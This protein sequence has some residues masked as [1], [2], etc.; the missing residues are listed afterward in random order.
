MQ[1]KNFLGIFF[2]NLHKKY[3][4]KFKFFQKF[5]LNAIGGIFC[6][7][8]LSKNHIE[9]YYIGKNPGEMELRGNLGEKTRG[10]KN[11]PQKKTEAQPRSF[12]GDYFWVRVFFCKKLLELPFTRM[13]PKT[14]RHKIARVAIHEDKP[15]KHEAQP[16]AFL[17]YPSE[18]QRVQFCAEWFLGSSEWMA[19]SA[20]L[21]KFHTEWRHVARVFYY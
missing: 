4:V 6:T 2:S 12:F 18:W 14:T 13:S 7:K 17:A 21:S 8:N 19:T 9:W 15:K 16:S 1:K 20:I 5:S 10:P 3:L 11:N